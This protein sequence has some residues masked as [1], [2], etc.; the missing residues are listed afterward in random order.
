[1]DIK[2]ILCPIDFS[3]FNHAANEYASILAKSTG[4]RLIYL[5]AVL[6]EVPYGS[7]AYIDMEVEEKKALMRL[8]EILPTIEGVEASYV[9]Q[10]GLPS[11]QIVAYTREHPIDLIVMGTHGRT[12]L[13]RVLM[14][15]VAEAVVR[16]ARCPVLAIKADTREVEPMEAN[17]SAQTTDPC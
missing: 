9:V 17:N 7:Y 11:E 14:G 2:R 12:G 8:Q 13:R 3:D 16:N 1:M 10:F 15:S 4:A 6:P 5:H